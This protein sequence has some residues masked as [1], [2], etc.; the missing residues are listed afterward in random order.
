MPPFIEGTYE[1]AGV[2]GRLV[3][4]RRFDPLN[5]E[6]M[7]RPNP[8]PTMLRD[9]LKNL[10]T[11][12]RNFGGLRVVQRYAGRLMSKI[13]ASRTVQILD[14]ATGSADHPIALVE[15]ARSIGRSVRVTAVERNPLTASIARERTAPYKEIT[16]ELGNI[17]AM[18]WQPA[19][20][21][22]VLC[23]L[24]IHH[25]S[26]EDAVRILATMHR[27]ARVGIVVNDLNRSWP[28]AWTAWAYAHATSRNPMTRNDSY[29]SVLRA[30]TPR[31]L[32]S[33][34][35]EAG[36]RQPLVRRHPFF[37][38]VLVGEP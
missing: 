25:F 18:T 31:E 27:V 2:V 32:L 24:A 28:A 16:V 4:Q 30:F 21:D 19:S 23:S 36:I 17:L 37:R 10:R 13:D 12:N 11:I 22:I 20:F 26:R 5:P 8:D 3:P 7:D 1:T 6:L 34:A 29:V 14:L 38:L 15:F 33:M 35:T 9:D